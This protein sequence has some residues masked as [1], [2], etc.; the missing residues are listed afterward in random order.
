MHTSRARRRT[1]ALVSAITVALLHFNTSV[2]ARA[3]DLQVSHDF[4]I[5]A[6]SLDTA[7][8]QFSDQAK[9]QV[10]MW[11]DTHT[12][13]PSPGVMGALSAAKALTTILDTT[14]FVYQ[15]VDSETVAIV[16]TSAPQKGLTDYS[17]P[18]APSKLRLA[19]SEGAIG[20]VAASEAAPE[21]ALAEED[22]STVT[23]TGSHIIREGYST[24]TPVTAIDATELNDAAHPNIGDTL[25]QL[26]VFQGS[27]T[28]RNQTISDTESAQTE[29]N[30]RNLGASRTLVLFD[31]RR[32]PSSNT[33]AVPNVD[34]IPD[35]LI[36]RVDVVTGGASA[37]YGSDAV[38]GVV[39]YILDTNFTGVKVLA[40]GGV[41]GY[42]DGP[43]DKVSLTLGGSFFNDRLHVLLSGDH[44]YQAEIRGTARSWNT[45]GQGS[46]QN[47]AY[48]LGSP[49]PQFIAQPCCIATTYPAG[50]VILSGPLKGT[51]FG[52]GGSV[53]QYDFGYGLGT[54]G[55]DFYGGSWK[56]STMAG[57]ADIS[58]GDTVRHAFFRAGLDLTPDDQIFV[59]YFGGTNHTE[60]QCCYDY[61]QTGIG[62]LYTSNPYIPPS[63]L[64]QAQANNVTSFVLGNSLRF[65]TNQFQNGGLGVNNYHYQDV[66]VL[67]AK[68]KFTLAKTAWH[69][70]LYGQQGISV[71][72]ERI[73][74]ES[75]KANLSNAIEAV[76]VGSYGSGYTAAQYPNPRGI[77][78]GAITCLSNLLPLNNPGATSNCAPYNVFGTNVVSQA[79]IDY[80]QGNAH[81]RQTEKQTI[82]G[83]TITGAPFNDWAGPVSVALSAEWRHEI[84]DGYTDPISAQ[85]GFFSTNYFPFIGSQSV[86]EG[87]LETVVPLLHGLPGAQEV[88]FNGAAR[89][90][91]YS[92]S[93]YVT[94]WKMGLEWTPIDD[95]RFRGTQSMDIRAPNLSNLFGYSNGHGTTVD[96]F[97][98]NISVPSYTTTGGNL[99][100]KPEKAHQTEIG[101]VLQPSFIPGFHLSADW[102][103]IRITGA[104]STITA[105]FELQ[106]CFNSRIGNSY[107]GTSPY[108]SLITRNPDNS[109][110]SVEVIP[111]NVASFLAQ[112]IDYQVDY[113]S[114]LDSFF[115]KAPGSI[116]LSLAATQTQKLITNTGIPGPAQ[117]LNSAGYSASTTAGSGAPK[118]AAFASLAYDLDPWR[119]VWQERFV[120]AVNAANTYIQCSTNCPPVIPSGF[121][122]IGW[123]PRVPSYFLA[124]VSVQYKF[125]EGDR[126]KNAQLFLG[127]DNVFNRIPPW[128][129]TT[130]GQLFQVNTNPSLYD[131]LGLYVRAGIRLQL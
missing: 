16:K 54:A 112:G 15:Q 39:N 3:E 11:S 64:G 100:L 127:V 26:P 86:K 115:G 43:S 24:P 5:P 120:S 52:P 6:Q 18:E 48:T 96:P 14:G 76:R 59:E 22:L 97:A 83:G 81:M 30:L 77:A 109:L 95:I 58:V 31:G 113:R 88:D 12:N 116:Q 27:L 2:L 42:G 122:T 62:T 56:E 110:N 32:L 10:L 104:I 41:S 89:A 85:T 13:L 35:A 79:A 107:T 55:N 70:N 65:P 108:C 53:G 121:Q 34:L 125:M 99:A 8:L 75:I 4:K 119:F 40:E 91:D 80:T 1:A 90:T 123:D 9:V 19:Q 66:Y 103:R 73:V 126:G 118:W 37:V 102:W 94:T 44:E 98:G 21:A 68:G 124:N 131:T 38:S 50:G 7:L 47:P 28:N 101:L 33:E 63:V 72:D 23:I 25:N 130:P 46:M 71:E 82:A 29:M 57:G 117:S 84:A 105:Q 129:R 114:R 51:S 87:A 61:Y 106:E 74:G 78:T 69:W 20:P 93:G 92:T 128:A 36:Q 49:M 45:S 60:D 111:F 67:G 17:A